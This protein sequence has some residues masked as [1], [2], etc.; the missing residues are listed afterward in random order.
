MA[1]AGVRRDELNG[2]RTLAASGRGGSAGVRAGRERNF[3]TR[4]NQRV[5]VYPAKPQAGCP[6]MW[7]LRAVGFEKLDKPTRDH[8]T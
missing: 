4:G 2:A 1:I 3:I 8:P 5:K 6:G 7:R